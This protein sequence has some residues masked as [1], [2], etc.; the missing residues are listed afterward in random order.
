MGNPKIE[1]VIFDLGGVLVDWNPEYL[2]SK[3]FKDDPNKM[4]WFLNTVCSP[5][6]NMEQDAGR[7]FD[8][9]SE[10]LIQEYP[11]YK[12]EILV[13]YERWE[14]MLKSEIEDTVLILNLLKELNKVKLYALTNWSSE[15][16]PIAQQR[17][18][19]LKQF[20]G[21]VVSGEE[22]TRKPYSKIYKITLER[23]QLAPETCLFIDDSIDNVNA[24]KS[25]NINALHYTNAMQ[26]RTDL[27]QLGLLT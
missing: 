13:F 11:E 24:A 4:K 17:F 7:S 18:G 12:K 3:I 15:T 25:L 1:T 2:Y 27:H 10:I 22:N 9:G 5:S 21:I 23:Y 8:E 14:E 6:W 20:E 16:F 26:L 19:F